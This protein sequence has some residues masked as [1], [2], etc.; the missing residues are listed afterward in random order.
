M[1]FIHLLYVPTMACNLRCRYCYLE[2]QT[3]SGQPQRPPLETLT[4]AVDQFQA[5]GVIPFNISLHGGEVTTL[6]PEDFRALVRYISEYYAQNGDEI[7]Q[8]G[9][10][11]GSPHIK[12]N[13]FGL[14]RHIDAIRDYQVSVSGSL[15][16]PFSLHDAYRVTAGGEPTLQKIL[17][18]VALMESLP[19]RKKVS[20]TIFRQHLE[21]VDEL[22][23]DIWF[24]HRNTCLNM[25]D[26]NFMIG[27]AYNSSGLLTPLTQEEQVAFYQR[28][29]EAFQGTE[30]SPGLEGPWFAEF[31]PGYCTN[32]DVCGEKFFL[33]ENGGDIYSCVRGQGH[34]EFYYGNICRDSVAQILATAGEKIRAAHQAQGFD[35]ACADC[36]WLYL[37]KTGCPFVKTLYH[38]PRS[39]TCRLQQRLYADQGREKDPFGAETVYRYLSAVQPGLM[40]DY[41]PP[42][43]PSGVP[44]LQQLIR[45]DPHL[46]YIYDPEA[47]ILTVDGRPFPLQSQIRRAE[48]EFVCITPESTVFI[49]VKKEVMQAEC[50]EPVNNALYIQLLSGDTVRYGDEGRVKQRHVVNEMVYFGVLE[51]QPP[52]REGYYRLDISHLFRRYGGSL[53]REEANN[54]FFTT[55]ALRDVHYAKQKNNAFYHMQAMDL[56]F[57]NIEFYF[58][59][60]KELE[61]EGC[62]D[63]SD[64]NL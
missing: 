8:A 47:F 49:D 50:A 6:P 54:L 22:I 41:A 38:S 4:F 1:P 44:P 61:E 37:C 29:R 60:L 10:P 51:Q 63:G 64:Q 32:C 17:Q 27:F 31:G 42:R 46:R 43:I 11:V 58:L 19:N 59:S 45:E 25:N 13:L 20:A 62:Q 14:D 7:R 24:L 9:F 5:A 16:L 57:Q 3:G 12:T 33:L 53:S 21:R 52:G 18:N 30:L 26:F 39:Y 2:G 40:Q 48:R 56:P 35:P 23:E 34:P 36:G 28:I 15:D 55:S